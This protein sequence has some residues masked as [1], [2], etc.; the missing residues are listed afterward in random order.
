MSKIW[1]CNMSHCLLFNEPDMFYLRY[2]FSLGKKDR[3]AL[4]SVAHGDFVLMYFDGKINNQLHSAH[5]R[6]PSHGS[7]GRN[8]RGLCKVGKRYLLSPISP[9]ELEPG[10][11]SLACWIF[12]PPIPLTRDITRRL[13]SKI[14]VDGPFDMQGNVKERYFCQFS[15]EALSGLGLR[16]SSVCPEWAI[17]IV[18][19]SELG[20]AHESAVDS[21][22]TKGIELVVDSETSRSQ[23]IARQQAARR[24]AETARRTAMGANGQEATRILKNKEFRFGNLQELELHVK[25]LIARQN[26]RCAITG[27]PLQFDDEHTDTELLCSLDRIDSDGHY[28]LGNLQVVCRFVNRWKG[29]ENDAQFRRLIELIRGTHGA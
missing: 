5:Y 7:R 2:G 18:R 6:T 24:M 15:L 28:E 10:D 8:L 3:E 12:N 27:L 21:A 16:S 9:P 20:D 1:W 4:D 25:D 11:I 26:A 22:S 14:A 17:P 29:D 13:R 19:H 23:S